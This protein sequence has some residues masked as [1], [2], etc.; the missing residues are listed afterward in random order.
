MQVLL[1][2]ATD[3]SLTASAL[4]F[5]K[6]L[7]VQSTLNGQWEMRDKLASTTWNSIIRNLI[8]ANNSKSGGLQDLTVGV[9]SRFDKRASLYS[10]QGMLNLLEFLCSDS[11]FQIEL[12]NLVLG[13]DT[14]AI[15]V[16]ILKS[17]GVKVVCTDTYRPL[18]ISMQLGAATLLSRKCLH[19]KGDNT[20]VIKRVLKR[21]AT[22]S[23]FQN[24][25]TVM[26][27][28]SDEDGGIEYALN[29]SASR[30]MTRRVLNLQSILSIVTNED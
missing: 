18:K 7:L 11:Q 17:K 10:A 30:D 9:L 20:T 28:R 24:D 19:C 26:N 12:M 29:Q 25:N 8:H 3:I 4:L 6:S 27:L 14:I 23:L 15:L 13:Q 21:F 22:N 5:L 2:I 16:K 1:N